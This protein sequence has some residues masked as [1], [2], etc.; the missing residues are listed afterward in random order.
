MLVFYIERKVFLYAGS[1]LDGVRGEVFLD[2]QGYLK[3]DSIFKLSQIK[4]CELFDLFKTIDEGISVNKELSGSFGNVQVVFKE[5]LDG[6]ERFL[7]ERFDRASF[8]NFFEEHIAK[9]GGE[10]IDQTGDAE[11]VVAD[12]GA[13]RIEYFADLKSDLSQEYRYR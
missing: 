9:G 10:L 8:E 12:D 6:K 13:F 2:H 5:T 4:P 7:I 11:V 3:D 1:I